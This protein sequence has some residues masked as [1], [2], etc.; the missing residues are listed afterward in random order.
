MWL[1]YV[2]NDD[3]QIC[4]YVLMAISNMWYIKNVGIGYNADLQFYNK[5][6]HVGVSQQQWTSLL[7]PSPQQGRP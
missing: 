3:I 7:S 1:L 5:V 6:S 4:L 2:L